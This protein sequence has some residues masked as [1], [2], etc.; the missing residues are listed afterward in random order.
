MTAPGGRGGLVVERRA[1]AHV[2]ARHVRRRRI[3]R[4][5]LALV[6]AAVL[7]LLGYSLGRA[8]EEAPRPGGTQMRIRTIEPGTLPPVTRTVTVTSASE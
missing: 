7:F 8:V 4:V 5:A 6:A 1:R 2:D 3:V